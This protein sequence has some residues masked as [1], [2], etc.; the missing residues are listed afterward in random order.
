V[1]TAP[2]FRWSDALEED[3]DL[4]LPAIYCRHCGRSGWG[5]TTRA[6]GDDLDLRP[7]TIRKDSAEKN[8]RFRAL[9]LDVT[10]T[11]EDPEVATEETSRRRYLNLSSATLDRHGPLEDD[12]DASVLRVLVHA[13][14]DADK[15]ANDQTCPACG[16]KDGIRFLGTRLATLLSVSLTSL[17]GTPGLDLREKKAL[18]FTDSVQDAAHRAGFV[19][20][21]SYSLTMR[22]VIHDALTTEPA[23]I[24]TVVERMLAKATTDEQRYRLLHPTI[25]DSD[26]LTAYWH[27]DA[28][29]R[30]GFR[31]RDRERATARVIKRL[32]FDVG[33][34][35]GL[36]GQVGRTL[37]LTGSALAQV[38][39]SDARARPG[40]RTRPRREHPSARRRRCGRAPPLGARH[41]RTPPHPRRDRPRLADALPPRRRARLPALGRTPRAGAHARLPHR[42]RPPAAAQH[43]PPGRQERARGRHLPLRL[44]RRLDRPGARPR[45][46]HRRDVPAPAA[47]RAHRARTCSTSSRPPAAACAAS[48]WSRTASRPAAP[49][50]PPR[51]RPRCSSATNAARPSPAPTPCSPRCRTGRACATAAPEPSAPQLER[52]LLPQPLPGRHAPRRRPRA[53]LPARPPRTASPT[54]RASRTAPR[55]PAPR[56]SWSPPPPSRWASTSATSPPC[57][58]PPSR[59]TVASYLQRVGRAGRQTGNALDVTFVAG[60]G[61]AAGLYYDPLDLLN[62][63]VRAP[64]AYLS[65]QEILRRQLLASVLDT[66]AGDDR[67][68]PPVRTTPVLASAAPGTFLGHVIEELSATANGTS[69]GSSTASPPAP[70][71]G[72]ASPRTPAPSCALGSAAGRRKPAVSRPRCAEPSKSGTSAGRSCGAVGPGSRTTSSSSR[73]SPSPTSAPRRWPRCAPRTS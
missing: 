45:P 10:T 36:T 62:G 69:N 30:R 50:A 49:P 1:T 16:E 55:R 51:T 73:T 33:L 48:R 43:R 71:P 27:Q 60:R 67:V 29:R 24:S 59:S 4:A 52:H 5:A 65:A 46:R 18:V 7:D 58:S 3:E 26:K 53:H 17:F 22:S 41:P 12:P 28:D 54:R 9:L 34:E 37:L 68:P 21:R 72:T 23:P 47:R 8:G 57:C 40:R 6:V 31:A 14:L 2:A 63:T 20:A 44:V 35:L 64:G 61:R 39:A 13:G 42:A 70:T 11:D 32:T 25:T 66:L 38:R 56:T 15:H 19:E